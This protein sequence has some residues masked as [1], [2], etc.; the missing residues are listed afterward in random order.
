VNIQNEMHAQ[1]GILRRPLPALLKRFELLKRAQA[2]E[3]GAS[4]ET[5]DLAFPHWND[6]MKDPAVRDLALAV[7]YLA[8]RLPDL[9]L[10]SSRIDSNS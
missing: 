4:I 9:G 1:H 7:A 3:R 6:R 2:P 10:D 8:E 5:L